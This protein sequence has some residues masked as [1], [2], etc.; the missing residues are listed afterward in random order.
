MKNF[1]TYKTQIEIFFFILIGISL[2]PRFNEYY[3]F[4]SLIFLIFFLINLSFKISY[5]IIFILLNIISFYYN[6]QIFYFVSIIIPIYYYCHINKIL[7]L[8]DYLYLIAYPKLITLS[9]HIFKNYDLNG[10]IV[11][12]IQYRDYTLHI[13]IF[14]PLIFIK[15]INCTVRIIFLMTFLYFLTF[16]TNSRSCFYLLTLMVI[17]NSIYTK[18][19][20]YLFLILLFIPSLAAYRLLTSADIYGELIQRFKFGINSPTRF[21][22]DYPEAISAI[23]SNNQI[24]VNPHNLYLN[25]F[26]NMGMVSG[27][28]LILISI[29]THIIIIKDFRLFNN[30]NFFISFRVSFLLFSIYSFFENSNLL[31]FFIFC[32]YFIYERFI[33]NSKKSFNNF[34]LIN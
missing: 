8:K 33:I 26:I 9:Y 19:F 1:T 6:I 5:K 14:S 2:V 3:P 25:T 12:P 11:N 10:F 21:S 28:L 4:I 31:I 32:F 23:I 22:N 30:N 15:F 7:L 16:I 29:F 34:N 17:L 20:K 24:L 18:K 13:L 27:I